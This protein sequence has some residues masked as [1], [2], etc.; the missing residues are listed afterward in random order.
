MP[1]ENDQ[2]PAPSKINGLAHARKLASQNRDLETYA[3]VMRT[4]DRTGDVSNNYIQPIPLYRGRGVKELP[5]PR[6]L[7]AKQPA[8]IGSFHKG[9]KV[10]K[11]GIYRLREGE[12]VIPRRGRKTR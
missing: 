5:P 8:V 1:E 11:T 2:P 4:D 9:G 10:R 6:Q 12:R 3:Q 7:Q